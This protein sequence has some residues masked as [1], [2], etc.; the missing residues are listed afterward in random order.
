[1]VTLSTFRD[2]KFGDDYGVRIVDGPLAGLMSRAVIV[3]DESG[4]VT[5][6]EQVTEIVDE[7]DYEAALSRL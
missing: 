1:M 7:P 5:H 6:S 2:R 4:K 3:I